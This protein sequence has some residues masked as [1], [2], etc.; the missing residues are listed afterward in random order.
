MQGSIS[1]ENTSFLRHCDIRITNGKSVTDASILEMFLSK[2]SDM[3]EIA[4]HGLIISI[5]FSYYGFHFR[6]TYLND[7]PHS[8]FPDQ[9]VNRT[10]LR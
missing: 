9:Y 6:S 8:Q 3:L 10:L 4:E 5:I 7:K 2:N 1:I